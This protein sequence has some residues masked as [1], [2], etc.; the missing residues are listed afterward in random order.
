MKVHVVFSL[1]V[2]CSSDDIHVIRVVISDGPL[3]ITGGEGRGGGVKNFRCMNFVLS[4]LVRRIFFS[5]VPA[6]HKL[7]TTTTT[8][9]TLYFTP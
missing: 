4:P 9:I 1:N 8:T 2:T 7:F 5:E 6:S 3:E